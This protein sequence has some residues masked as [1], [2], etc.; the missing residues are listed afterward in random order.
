[1]CD[2]ISCMTMFRLASFTCSTNF[3]SRMVENTFDIITGLRV[4]VAECDATETTDV[5][6]RID[7]QIASGTSAYVCIPQVIGWSL[8][9]FQ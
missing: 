6:T 9:Q 2:V 8:H 1:M 5:I 3:R 4:L 7:S